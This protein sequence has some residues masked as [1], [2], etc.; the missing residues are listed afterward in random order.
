[1]T[2]GSRECICSGP[3]RARQQRGKKSDPHERG[4]GGGASGAR[5][6]LEKV[7]EH[8]G[9]VTGNV[10]KSFL[11]SYRTRDKFAEARGGEQH[12]TVRATIILV[13][14]DLPR[15]VVQRIGSRKTKDG[16]CITSSQAF[17]RA[18]ASGCATTKGRMADATHVNVRKSLSNCARG[19]IRG[20]DALAGGRDGSSGSLELLGVLVEFGTAWI[21]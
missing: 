10:K 17:K 1:M 5:L 20:Q 15:F 14:L 3:A 7:N 21:K 8:R 11:E 12:L 18:S 4:G 6:L 9:A 16:C 2:Q 13:V 19:L